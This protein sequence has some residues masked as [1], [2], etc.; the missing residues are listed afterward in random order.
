MPLITGAM[1]GHLTVVEGQARA[2]DLFLLWLLSRFPGLCLQE[3]RTALDWAAEKGHL[4]VVEV[5][6]EA[7]LAAKEV[8]ARVRLVSFFTSNTHAQYP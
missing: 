6:E 8:S 1:K 2:S 7:A 3:K 5:L 4:A